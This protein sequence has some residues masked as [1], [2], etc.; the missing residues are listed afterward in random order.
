MK[1]LHD[2]H[3]LIVD[4]VEKNVGVRGGATYPD[5][6]LKTLSIYLILGSA[7]SSPHL[8]SRHI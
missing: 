3:V 1:G 5:L 8:Y 7:T 2:P 6:F 4:H